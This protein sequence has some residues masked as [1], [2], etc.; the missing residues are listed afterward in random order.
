MFL[1]SPPQS[2][3]QPVAEISNFESYRLAVWSFWLLNFTYSTGFNPF[4]SCISKLN[5]RPSSCEL[6]EACVNW[7]GAAREKNY[8]KIQAEG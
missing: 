2:T 7:E 1:P 6:A 5:C 8:G 3:I 4:V